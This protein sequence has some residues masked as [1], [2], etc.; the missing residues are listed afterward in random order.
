MLSCGWG[1]EG[2]ISPRE[3]GSLHIVPSCGCG[4]EAER[5]HFTSYHLVGGKGVISHRERDSLP[6]VASQQRIICWMEEQLEHPSLDPGTAEKYVPYVELPGGQCHPS[7]LAQTPDRTTW[8]SHHPIPLQSG[9]LTDSKPKVIL[10]WIL[11]A[12]ALIISRGGQRNA[13]GTKTIFLAPKKTK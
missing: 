11:R 1:G 4:G 13:V 9:I 10:Y 7:P 2:V 3:R 12:L 5:A 6:A 8:H